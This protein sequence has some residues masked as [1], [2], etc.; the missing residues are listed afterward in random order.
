M[1][2]YHNAYNYIADNGEHVIE[3]VDRDSD[4]GSE[5][6]QRLVFEN[7]A[8]IRAV[9]TAATSTGFSA[10]YADTNCTIDNRGKVYVKLP[11]G[12]SF[13]TTSGTVQTEDNGIFEISLASGTQASTEHN[14]LNHKV[15]VRSEDGS[16]IWNGEDAA[17]G[18]PLKNLYATFTAVNHTGT[19]AEVTGV[20]E[21]GTD[22]MHE[23][24]NAWEAGDALVGRFI[25]RKTGGSGNA[26]VDLNIGGAFVDSWSLTDGLHVLT[27]TGYCID[28]T[29][30]EYAIDLR[31][32]NEET[33]YKLETQTTSAVATGYSFDVNCP[34]G[35]IVSFKSAE[36]TGTRGG[37][38]Y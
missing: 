27:I 3:V 14:I 6:A 26:T 35:D 8:D 32:P 30:Q 13:F 2:H 15:K 20:Y 21:P 37:K 25:I 4:A 23:I 31:G 17:D 11:A 22:G 9:V 10:I 16:I 34:S 12:F 5:L 7:G 18:E 1:D 36:L 38:I 28:G 29:N 24:W 33:D 19:G